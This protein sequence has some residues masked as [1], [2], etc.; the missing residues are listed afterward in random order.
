MPHILP[1]VPL[2]PQ[3]DYGVVYANVGQTLLICYPLRVFLVIN[4]KF[5]TQ[6]LRSQAIT[7][8]IVKPLNHM[9]FL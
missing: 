1:Q 2:I 5:Q 4:N 6:D 7:N 3:L 8:A 9:L